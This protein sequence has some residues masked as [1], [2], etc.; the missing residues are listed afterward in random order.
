MNKEQAI[1]VA[2]AL[3]VNYLSQRT[4]MAHRDKQGYS[5]QH[6]QWMVEE[7]IHYDM[8]ENKTMRWLGYIQGVMVAKGWATLADMKTLNRS[9]SGET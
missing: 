3:S 1:A 6:L 7:I 8:S 4:I 2:R 5:P 9:V